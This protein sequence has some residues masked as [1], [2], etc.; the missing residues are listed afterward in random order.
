MALAEEVTPLKVFS[1]NKGFVV[2]YKGEIKPDQ[3]IFVYDG[4]KLIG[5]AKVVECK[6]KS[7]KATF[8]KVRKNTSITSDHTF[9]TSMSPLTKKPHEKGPEQKDSQDKE[10][11]YGSYGGVFNYGLQLGY[12]RDIGGDFRAGVYFGS[13]NHDFEKVNLKSN[14]LALQS[15]YRFHTFEDSGI[16]FGAYGEAGYS[17]ATIDYSA[18]QGGTIKERAP[19]LATGAIF[20]KELDSFYFMF[21]GGY[22]YNF[23]S[24]S[25]ST[26]GRVITT[27]FDGGLFALEFGAGYSF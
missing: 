1:G 10:T 12:L 13:I 3:N 24:S 9:S 25:V 4:E 27:P 18:Y 17:F 19:F 23:H 26:D 14:L 5:V 21:K 7:C 6:T 2:P 8:R 15:D 22:S 16:H 20:W 11:V